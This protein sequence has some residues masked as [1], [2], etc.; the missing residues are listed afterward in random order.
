MATCFLAHFLLIAAISSRQ[1]LLLISKNLTLIRTSERS[2]WDKA[3]TIS[4]IALGENL[5]R[6][7]PLRQTL[8]TYLHLS[9][10]ETGYG[11]FAP[12]VPGAGKLVFEIHYRDGR[13][14][15]E[16]PHVNSRAAQ[17]RLAGLLDK[18]AAEEYEPLRKIMVKML[19][20]SVWREHSDVQSVRAVFGTIVLPTVTEFKAGHGTSSQFLY[21]Y[22]VTN[23]DMEPAAQDSEK[24]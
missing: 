15:Y 8:A 24:Q 19:T 1:T 22:D 9:G 17:L 13:V 14:E 2:S 10:I 7:H 6:T 11:Y 20:S 23:G 3:E 5:S 4:S 16:S 12:N 21:A 18:M